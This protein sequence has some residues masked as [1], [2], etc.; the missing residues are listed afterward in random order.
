M[1]GKS[2]PIGT[3]HDMARI[4]VEAVD[5]FLAELPG[6]LAEVR[7]VQQ[8]QQ[9]FN[10]QFEGV[11][12]FDIED[13]GAPE[14]TDDDLAEA[15]ITVRLPDGDRMRVSRPLSSPNPGRK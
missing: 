12:K 8:A 7:H 15:T 9:A 13:A 5:R 2:Y 10:A 1:D 14:W 4:P 11:M 6:I 3:L